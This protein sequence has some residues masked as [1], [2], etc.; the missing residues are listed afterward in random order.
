[1]RPET[2]LVRSFGSLYR[3]HR[4]AVHLG[5]VLALAG[6]GLFALHGLLDQVRLRDVSA[7]LRQLNAWRWACALALTA[8]SYVLLTFHDVLALQVIGK[9][10]PWRTAALA[11]FTSYTLSH[12]LGLSLITGGSARYRIYSGSGLDAADVMRVIANAS[13]A[14]WS[15]V[16]VM[17]ALAL[18]LHPAALPMG[19]VLIE[20][21]LQSLVGA[22]LLAGL[23]G[24]L[25]TARA[26]GR[27]L[28]L[29]RWALPLP[30]AR[31]AMIQISVA[32][33]DLL[34]ASAA[35][36]VL[37]PA[38]S[39]QAFPLFFLAYALAI[40]AALVTHV[41]GGVGV[42]EAVII[43]AVPDVAKPAMLAALIAY[44]AIYYLLPLLVAALMLAVHERSV[45]RK[46][47]VLALDASQAVLA[48]MAPRCLAA[49][50]FTG[51]LMLL[52]SGSLPGIPDRLLALRSFVP[53][54][55]IEASHI[56]ASLAGT[57]LLLLAPGL[58]RRLDGAFLLTRAVLLAGAIFS[59]LKGFDYE[60]AV[61]LLVIAAVLQSTRRAF[62]R[63]TALT[64]RYFTPIWMAAVACALGLSIWIGFFAFKHVDYADDL[65]W[66]F[67]WNGDASRFL[68]ASV[69]A[70]VLVICTI[71]AWLFGPAIED[72][73]EGCPGLPRSSG[74]LQ[75]STR[76]CALLAWTGDKRFLYSADETAFVMYQIQGHTW[77]VMG[78]P[79]G[80]KAA[81]ADLLWQLRER[82]DAA[83]GRL[84]LYQLTAEALPIAIDLGLQIVKYGEDANVDL[85][86]FSLAGPEAKGLRYAERR[87]LRDGASF[88]IIP[89]ARVP[90]ILPELRSVSDCWLAKKG[91]TEKAFSVG[92]F[93]PAY[94]VRFDCAVVRWESRIVA[95]ANI[96]STRSKDEISVDLMRHLD[97]L[98][99]GTMDFLFLRLM[100]WAQEEGYR[101]F[102]LGVSPLAGIE[103]R[104]LAPIWAKA[105]ALLYRHGEDF[106]GFEGL[107]AF[108]D[109][110]SPVW[111]PRYVAGP[112]GLGM[113]RAMIDLQALVGG[114]R[115]SAARPA[116]LAPTAG[117]GLQLRRTPA[118]RGQTTTALSDQSG[119]S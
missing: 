81:W 43:A 117:P 75:H 18:V 8:A 70:A 14:F 52:L 84:M 11:S 51:G 9:R 37:V 114:G 98:P 109:K 112:F 36:F 17:A 46:P 94:L 61:I 71:L 96:W 90:A 68:R 16:I 20:P 110:F 57:A 63:R 89:A 115:S 59:L 31:Q 10:L 93:D 45:W 119:S 73:E 85:A 48:V 101:W 6:I 15:G 62:Y 34:A 87:A 65:W 44:R 107:R 77:I 80:P 82:A 118:L 5:A 32:S 60:E 38:L 3:R 105:G 78:D 29:G 7:A 106:Y 64:V 69:A 104:K 66:Q 23:A 113:A 21:A 76:T 19:P 54:P 67:A 42:F 79:V 13:L 103:A 12:N 49:L 95:F 53:L 91:H 26:G 25:W 39:P 27:K 92:R 86:R 28:R 108:K 24:L 99:Y 116:M 4:T 40:I 58:Y 50:T 83:Q 41:P 22:A 55:F 97:R 56:A 1:M 33:L 47:V 35:L 74:P 111:E 2:A 102:N 100:A 88:E 30:S 72:R